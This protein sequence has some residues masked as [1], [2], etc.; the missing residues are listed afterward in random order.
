MFLKM[1]GGC[2][3]LTCGV[4][5][6]L[7]SLPHNGCPGVRLLALICVSPLANGREGDKPG[8]SGAWGKKDGE[9]K[10]EFADESVMRIAPHGD[11]NVIAIVCDYTVENGTLV[12]AKVTGF[13]GSSEEAKK[14]IAEHLPVGVAFSFQWTTNGDG[15]RLENVKGDKIETLKSHLEGSFEK[16]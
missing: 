5:T 3:V 11:S 14:K 12:K 4:L 6:G 7:H 9:L 15:A 2:T 1:L 16:K 8:L 10:I 13:E